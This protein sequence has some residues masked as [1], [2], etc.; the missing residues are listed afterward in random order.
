MDIITIIFIAFALAM[1]AFAVSVASG[2]ATTR[3]LK[4][5]H[6]L[7]IAIFFGTF[8][9]VMPLI[10]WSVG[11]SLRNFISN[12]DHWL[13]F[14]LLGLIG[15]RMIYESSR[16]ESNKKEINQLSIYI[17]L[18]LSIATSI[19][20]LVIGISF[21]FLK[22]FIITPIIVIGIITF[23]LSFLGVF[24]GSSLGHFFEKKI[25][26]VG[27]LILISIGIKTLVEHLG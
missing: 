26:I 18:M 17:L 20:A 24:I 12:I 27:G 3:H 16:I 2:G 14:G 1:D 8:Q 9:A 5:E 11:I 13:A 22:I 25:E 19:D 4:I 21:A 23:L 10:G 7:K 15:C 6:A